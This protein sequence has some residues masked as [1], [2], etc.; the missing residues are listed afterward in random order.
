VS[1]DQVIEMIKEKK[2]LTSLPV[3]ANVDFGHTNPKVTLPVGG[4]IQIEV[5][6]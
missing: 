3:V 2:E 6:G 1:K 5:L 4:K